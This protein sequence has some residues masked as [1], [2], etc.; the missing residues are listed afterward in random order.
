MAGEIERTDRA[1]EP[2]YEK[3]AE[4]ETPAWDYLTQTVGSK[5][6]SEEL[7]RRVRERSIGL[8]K[9]LTQVRTDIGWSDPSVRGQLKDWEKLYAEY[10]EIKDRLRRLLGPFPYDDVPPLTRSQY[11]V[12]RWDKAKRYLH[13]FLYRKD[14]VQPDNSERGEGAIHFGEL[15]EV[16][17]S[18]RYQH[19]GVKL[20]DL[21]EEE[22]GQVER[23]RDLA[24]V[25]PYVEENLEE[26]LNPHWTIYWRFFFD[27]PDTKSG[28]FFG[29]IWPSVLGTLLLAVGTMIIATP[30]GVI[31]AVYLTQYAGEGRL[32]SLLRVCI[33]TL[34]GVPSVVFGLFGLAFF[35]NWMH[36]SS[37]L[38][39]WMVQLGLTEDAG[40]GRSV[41]IG[42]LTLALLVLPTVIRASEEAIR[43][44]PKSYKEGSLSLG[45]TKWQT[46]VR[47]IL[48]ASLPGIITSII[49][50]MGRAAGE[51][52]PILFTAA[53]A[54]SGGESIGL[55]DSLISP[56]PALPYSIYM[57]IGEPSGSEI[58]HVQYGM[59]FTLIGLVL[60]LNV[61]AI[62]LRAKTS[63]KLRG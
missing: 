28:Y 14:Y 34:A 27:R 21:T 1:R 47:V 3:L 13:D 42:C 11:G 24:S 30:M 32:I 63:K 57:T 19:K 26:M 20:E 17:R 38:G 56:T 18:K 15:V 44:V 49:I 5:Q 10:F 33:S 60:L 36:L 16:R 22:R 43:A 39:S 7:R 54:F 40:R 52:A 46:I 45:A 58:R 50:S 31:S 23:D 55:L 59:V 61:T 6:V 8:E 35:I 37:N 29:G 53:V 41:L 12:T 2:V 48:P 62:I 25:F 9:A 51:T 4:Y